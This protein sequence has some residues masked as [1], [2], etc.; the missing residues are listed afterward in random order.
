MKKSVLVV[1]CCLIAMMGLS[2]NE[3]Y[4]KNLFIQNADTLR[5]RIMYPEGYQPSKKYPV[6]LVLH[7]AGERGND[8]EK[9]LVHGSKLFASPENRKNFPAIVIFPQCPS[10]DFWARVSV[11]RRTDSTPSVF[12][13]P[14]DAPIGKSLN[15]VTQLMD[16]MVKTGTVNTRK[17]YVGG[18][19]M[20][21]MGTFEL[22]WRRPDLFAAAFPICG[23]GAESK[24]PVYGRKFPI[25]VFHGEADDVVPVENSRKMVA[26]LKD[27]RAKVRYSEYPGVNHNSWDAAFGEKDLLPWMFDKK[28]KR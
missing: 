24:A 11:R 4:Q 2:Q 14:V 5:F 25:W 17:I 20:G 27:A 16:S 8:N 28:K 13:F 19:S 18:L 15:L 3:L 6:I 26:A 9:Q 12:Q 22:L 10:N 7:G 21:G 1:T 23:G